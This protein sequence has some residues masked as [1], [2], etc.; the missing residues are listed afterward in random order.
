VAGQLDTQKL[1]R[2]IY[3]VPVYSARL[4]LSGRFGAVHI[5][6]V[7]SGPVEEVRWNDAKFVLPLSAVAGLKSAAVLRIDDATNIAFAPSVGIG[8]TKCGASCNSG[9][10]ARLAA[11]P[12]FVYGP[13]KGFAFEMA[14]DFNGS[15]SLQVA[16]VARETR[17]SLKSDWPSPSFQ[18]AFLPSEREIRPNGFVASWK[19]PQLARSIPAAWLLSEAGPERLSSDVF[20][21]SLVDPVNSYVRLGRAVKYGILL[22]ATAFMAVFCLEMLAVQRLHPVQYLLTGIALIFFYILL[23]SLS[24]HMGFDIAY[25]LGASA[26]VLMVASYVG[27]VMRSLRRGLVMAVVLSALMVILYFTLCLE[28]YALLV[29]SLLGIVALGVTMFA[30]LRVNWSGA[31]GAAPDQA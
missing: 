19:V 6:E 17:L 22:I 29:G 8:R 1:H 18:G 13:D 20:G 21:V 23:L 12:G 4:K 3:D 9:I 5:A 25:G 26:M 27:G 24:E 16:P 11:A 15:L 31:A 10:H 30:T 7:E 2:S 28:D 14:L